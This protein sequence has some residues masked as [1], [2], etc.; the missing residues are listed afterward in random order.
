MAVVWLYY[1]NLRQVPLLCTSRGHTLDFTH[2]TQKENV[3][4]TNFPK[5]V[6]EFF[7]RKFSA[8][9][10]AWIDANWN[11][12]ADIDWSEASYAKMLKTAKMVL[13]F[14]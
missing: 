1:T 14:R 7:A 8:E 9:D 5:N 3:M 6:R 11:D 10:L 4:P 2:D 13:S 12:Y